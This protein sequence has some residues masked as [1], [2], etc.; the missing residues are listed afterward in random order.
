N[1]PPKPVRAI[2]S[3]CRRS[4]PTRR[5]TPARASRSNAWW[6]VATTKR[7]WS[8]STSSRWRN[9]TRFYG[10]IR[11]T[12]RRKSV[13]PRPPTTAVTPINPDFPNSSVHACPWPYAHVYWTDIGHRE[14]AMPRTLRDA[15]LETRAARGRLKARGKPYYRALE[16]GLHLGYRRPQAGAGKW[17]ARHYVGNQAY[18]LEI[19]A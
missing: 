11:F 8:T 15:A 6:C 13:H 7:S 19:L 3:M 17:L 18:E 1:S 5:S 16:P 10:S 2:S 12:K 14:G 9:L 4:Y